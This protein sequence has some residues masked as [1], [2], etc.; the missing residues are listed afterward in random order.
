MKNV[1]FI[2]LAFSFKVCSAQGDTSFIRV[3]FLY[4]SKPAKGFKKTE[5]KRF[6]GIKGG[7]VNIE[8]DGRC[9]DF[10]PG[11]NCHVFPNKKNPNG[12]FC[13]HDKLKWDTLNDKS[14]YILVPVTKFQKD[15]LEKIFTSYSSQTP[16]DY[17]VFGNRCASASY[18]VLNYIGLV[19][20]ERS[21]L[22]NFYPKLVRKKL[23]KWAKRNNYYVKKFGGRDSRI[24]ESDQG[25]L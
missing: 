23:Y 3:N 13:I 18:R 2:C 15:S 19:D 17:A 9:L 4:G 6:G 25:L 11:G 14:A 21:V 22:S 24:W 5:S 1:L 16:F 7:H 20:K 10:G 8:M 12:K